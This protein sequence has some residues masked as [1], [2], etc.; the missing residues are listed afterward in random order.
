[1]EKVQGALSLR[2]YDDAIVFRQF[3]VLILIY[4]IT[5]M[6]SW[7]E[8]VSIICRHISMSVVITGLTNQ[9]P[10]QVISQFSPCQS[11]RLPYW[12]THVFTHWFKPWLINV[13]LIQ[14]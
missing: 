8:I 12:F 14:M 11:W 9:S 10:S 5:S 6:F 4:D 13:D 1:M 7:Y 2:D 3:L